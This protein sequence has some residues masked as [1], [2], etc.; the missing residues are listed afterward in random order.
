MTPEEESARRANGVWVDYQPERRRSLPRRRS[1]PPRRSS[2]G[3]WIDYQPERR[4][5]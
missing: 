1:P 4:R 3:Q 5:S 2:N